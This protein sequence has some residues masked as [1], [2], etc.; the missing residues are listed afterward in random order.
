MNL[1]QFENSIKSQLQPRVEEKVLSSG[2]RINRIASLGSE[3]MRLR[4]RTHGKK[5][6]IPFFTMEVLDELA[7]LGA[8]LDQDGFVVT[9]KQ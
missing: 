7:R 6:T 3:L 5:W 2:E 9:E 4:Q 1:L 8:S